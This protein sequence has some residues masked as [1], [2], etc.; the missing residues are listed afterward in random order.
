MNIA[1]LPQDVSQ[2]L[3]V[4]IEAATA[5]LGD[6]LVSI[7]L[8]GSAAE[9]KLRATSDVNVMLVLRRFEQSRI[10]AL[11]EALRLAH[12]L[13]RLEAMFVLESELADAAEAF[14]VKFADIATRHR[15]LA[16]R[17]LFEGLKP[18]RVALRNRIRQVL[19]NF[20]LRT[21]ERYALTSL[22]EEQLAAVVADAAAPLRSAAEA[23][24]ELEGKPAASPKE[25]LERLAR[26]LGGERWRATLGNLSA[27]R[28]S[29]ALAP[30]TAGKTVLELI[31]LAQRL[32]ERAAAPAA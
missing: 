7:A 2:P 23:I 20:I 15:I 16:G 11:R 31:D 22:R 26:E 30:G 9:A 6:D 24:L 1:D 28:E 3:S 18:S 8:F 27:A 17:D 25:A 12:A 32:R 21:R 13:I 5:S 29:G 14:A 10:D 4:F 19:L